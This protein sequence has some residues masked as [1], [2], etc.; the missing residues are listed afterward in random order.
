MSLSFSNK[1][2]RMSQNFSQRLSNHREKVSQ[3]LSLK[4]GK[5]S[6]KSKL[7]SPVCSAL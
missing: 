2:E 5:M 6:L 4:R 1:R 7:V 3:S